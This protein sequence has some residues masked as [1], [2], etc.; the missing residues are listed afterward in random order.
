MDPVGGDARSDGEASLLRWGIAG[1]FRRFPENTEW[2]PRGYIHFFWKK[3]LAKGSWSVIIGTSGQKWARMLVFCVH[4]P[5]C[6]HSGVRTM[7]N[8]HIDCEG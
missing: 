3:V 4:F 6:G 2:R 8:H 7:E 5:I 1:E